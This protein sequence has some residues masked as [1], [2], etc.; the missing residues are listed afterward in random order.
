M[1]KY[2][3]LLALGAWLA[4]SQFAAALDTV[5]RHKGTVNG[6]ITKVS[7]TEIEIEANQIPQTIP[8]NDIDAVLWDEE[9]SQVK[10]ARQQIKEANYQSALQALEKVAVP[11]NAR[12]QVKQDVEFYTAY[13]KAQMALGGQG[14]IKEAGTAMAMF[15]KNNP[16]SYHWLKA[17]EVVGDLLSAMGVYDKSLEYYAP[18]AKAPWPDYKMRAGVATGRALLAQNQIEKAQQQFQAVLATKAEGDLAT[19]QRQAAELGNARCLGALK[20]TDEA[21]KIIEAIIAKAD[22]EANDLLG[23][24]YNALGTAYRAAGKNKE[25]LMAFLHV[26]LIYYMHPDTHAEALFNLIALWKADNK[27]EREQKCLQTL[28]ARY[29]N[30]R[31]K[32]KG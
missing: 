11:Q 4:A 9:P 15:V 29:P 28:E 2:T 14:E 20:K 8:V 24:A 1:K 22:P 19:A 30:S 13:C 10:A 5:R 25:A 26:D 16:G 27:P 6:R 23:Q 18:L 12:E 31:W 17:N 7:P 21:I 32:P 3:I